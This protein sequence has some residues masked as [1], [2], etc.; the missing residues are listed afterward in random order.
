ML[1]SS[2]LLAELEQ[3]CDWLVVIGE[4]GRLFQGPPAGLVG[5]DTLALRPEH[6][7][8][9]SSLVDLVSARGLEPQLVGAR[10]LI[11][12]PDAEARRG[13]IAELVRAATAA[14]VT[15]V[16]IGVGHTHLEQSYL[17]LMEATQ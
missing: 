13:E 12:F 7:N 5:T 4:G 2:H 17:G 3:I 6:D 8:D 15:L 9:L 11:P 14:G 10:V 16:E 1:V